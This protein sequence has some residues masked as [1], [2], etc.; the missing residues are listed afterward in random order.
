MEKVTFFGEIE[1]IAL[2]QMVRYGKFDM[3]VKHFHSQY[4][5]FYI[6]EGERR[7]FFNNRE[8]V[9]RSGELILVDTNL[10]HMTKSVTAEDNGHNRVILYINKNKMEEFDQKYPSLQLV[11]FFHEHYGIYHLDHVQQALFLNLYH[12]LRIA[13]TKRDH[14]YKTGIELEIMSYLFKLMAYV[15]SQEQKLPQSSDKA[16][17]RTAYAVADYISDNCE[18][19]ISLEELASHFY[20]SKYYLCRIFKEI[21]GYTISEFTNIHRIRK[22]KRYLEETDMSVSEISHVLGY[23]SLTYFEKIFKSYMTIPPL[24]Y[25]KTLNTVTYT[26]QPTA[27]LSEEESPA[28]KLPRGTHIP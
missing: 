16:K 4:E 26:N 15:T 9:A 7:F 21:T 12:E 28:L 17:Y 14:N 27:C 23:E 8:Y 22:A 25:R 20:I 13:M 19:T 18:H 1:G 2:E 10:I 6:I 11:R 5:I 24:K 3:R